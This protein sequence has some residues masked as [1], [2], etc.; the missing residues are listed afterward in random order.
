MM[1]PFST[2]KPKIYLVDA[3]LTSSMPIL[4]CCL[5]QN[6]V[7]KKFLRQASL[8][9]KAMNNEVKPACFPNQSSITSRPSFPLASNCKLK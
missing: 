6:T 8:N 4:T 1:V 7:L 3:G 5:T 2:L 9:C